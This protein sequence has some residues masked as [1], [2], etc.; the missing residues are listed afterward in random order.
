MNELHIGFTGTQ[1][2]MNDDQQRWVRYA[3]QAWIPVGKTRLWFH[4][5]D[6]VGADAQAA[7]IAR[8]IG[9]LLHGHP[10]TVPNKRAWVRCD[11]LEKPLPPLTRN[12]EIVRASAQMLAAPWEE[13][14]QRRSGTW[15]TIR[16]A[17]REDRPTIVVAP[18]GQLSTGVV[19]VGK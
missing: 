3:L 8:E 7:E 6:C 14:E 1:R 16:Y 15:A 17:V 13:H 18:N 9:Y 19:K 4:H 10:S 2:G 5:G 12:L 11:R